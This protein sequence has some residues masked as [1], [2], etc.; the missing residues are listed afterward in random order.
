VSFPTPLSPWFVVQRVKEEDGSI[1]GDYLGLEF[2]SE[3]IDIPGYREGVE[4]NIV[5]QGFS[6]EP[7]HALVFTNLMNAA[8]VARAEEAHVRVLA[9]KE[10]LK[11]F[12][13]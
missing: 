6:M 4:E 3:S 9:S 5:V 13:K 1:S 2:Y 12:R 7:S 8:R 11:E 10:D